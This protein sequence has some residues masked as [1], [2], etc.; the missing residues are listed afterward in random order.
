MEDFDGL[1]STILECLI[2]SLSCM[3]SCW[4]DGSGFGHSAIRQFGRVG[5][6]RVPRSRGLRGFAESLCFAWGGASHVR[7]V[8]EGVLV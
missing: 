4:F 3:E 5:W 8:D 1:V 6:M 2:L 7:A